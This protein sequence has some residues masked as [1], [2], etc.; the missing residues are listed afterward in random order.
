ML[1]LVIGMVMVGISWF[2]SELMCPP[3]KVVYRYVPKHTLDI[4][5]GQENNP[6]EIYKDMFTTSSPWQGGYR[7]G[8]EK[9]LVTTNKNK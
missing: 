1:I 4:Q 3:P 8:N 9:T 5:F 6:S 2:K 7:L